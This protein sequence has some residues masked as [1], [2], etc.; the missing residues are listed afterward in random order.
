MA[1]SNKFVAVNFVS[2]EGSL[3]APS[4]AQVLGFTSCHSG[5]HMGGKGWPFH[6]SGECSTE[7]TLPKLICSGSSLVTPI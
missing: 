4:H 2:E 7:G 3:R 1:G 5:A 6:D